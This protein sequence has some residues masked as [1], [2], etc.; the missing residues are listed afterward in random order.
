MIRLQQITRVQS[1][2]PVVNRI[3]DQLLAI[4][5]PVLRALPQGIDN[6]PIITGS[7]GGNA[8]LQNLL[9]ALASMGLITNHTS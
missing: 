2:D 3:Q 1:E 7:T 9:A 8:A 4:V 6:K 5:N